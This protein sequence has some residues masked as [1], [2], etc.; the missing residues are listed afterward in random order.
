[1]STFAFICVRA[2]CVCVS[3]SAGKMVSVCIWAQQ[4]YLLK[5]KG[6]SAAIN[7]QLTEI[8]HAH[9]VCVVCTFAT[10]LL[11]R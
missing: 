10:H 2:L 3:V 7:F 8:K 6:I 9:V 4:I 1:M 5:V 11:T